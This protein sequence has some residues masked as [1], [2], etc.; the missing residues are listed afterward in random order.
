MKEGLVILAAVALFIA[1]LAAAQA[2]QRI[3]TTTC[4]PDRSICETRCL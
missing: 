2:Q 4:T 3:C 1:F